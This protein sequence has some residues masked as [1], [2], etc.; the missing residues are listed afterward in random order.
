METSEVPA[1]ASGEITVV[2][3]SAVRSGGESDTD[4][5][6]K[7][8]E[9]IMHLASILYLGSRINDADL[10]QKEEVIESKETRQVKANRQVD[11][12]SNPH[13]DRDYKSLLYIKIK[14]N[15]VPVLGMLDSGC[16]SSI[17]PDCIVHELGL[18]HAIDTRRRSSSKSVGSTGTTIGLVYDCP[19]EL[20]GEVVKHTFNVCQK[21]H[22]EVVIGLDLLTKLKC[23]IDTMH[24]KLI[25]SDR[26]STVDVRVSHPLFAHMEP[27]NKPPTVKD[28]KPKK[29]RIKKS[30]IEKLIREM[31]KQIKEGEEESEKNERDGTVHLI[32][33]FTFE[34]KSKAEQEILHQR[35]LDAYPDQMRKPFPHFLFVNCHINGCSMEVNVDTGAMNSYMSEECAKNCRLSKL[36]DTSCCT[37]LKGA[38]GHTVTTL[39]K[40]NCT[41]ITMGGFGFLASFSICNDMMEGTPVII[42]LDVLKKYS[43]II[44][45]KKGCMRMGKKTDIT[46]PFILIDPIAR[47]RAIEKER[48]QERVSEKEQ[49][50]R[51]KERDHAF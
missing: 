10:S 51:E 49:R 8:V 16:N 37:L 33:E 26:C 4:A 34:N 50:E 32:N 28:T 39:G 9:A 14:V 15:G 27:L 38:G 41:E 31:I 40:I 25:L 11:P 23:T 36:I 13:S 30:K 19:V 20:Q 5:E 7:A 22:I 29:I 1:S 42:G 21:T 2:L 24:D 45:F 47:E 18:N 12:T 44:D 35:F 6:D 46:V 48:E 43:F 17:I 3:E